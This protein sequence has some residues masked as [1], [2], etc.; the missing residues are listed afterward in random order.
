MQHFFFGDS[1]PSR[2]LVRIPERT[3]WRDFAARAVKLDNPSD[4]LYKAL[5]PRSARYFIHAL[6]PFGFAWLRRVNEDNVDLNRN[7]QDFLSPAFPPSQNTM[8]SMIG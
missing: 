1:N 3:A 8:H 7:F 2:L 5:P 4:R 6:N